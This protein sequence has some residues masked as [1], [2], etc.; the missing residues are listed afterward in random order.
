MYAL[1]TCFFAALFLATGFAKAQSSNRFL[2][3]AVTNH[4]SAFPFTEFGRLFTKEFNPGIEAGVGFY[5]KRGPKHDWFGRLN[6]GYFVHRFVQHALPL[7][8]QLGYRYKLLDRI[9][10]TGAFGVGYL[11]GIPATDVYKLRDGTYE[12]AKV[13]GRA[14]A[15]VSLT[16]GVQY[17]VSKTASKPTSLFLEYGQKLQM[18]FIRSYVPLLPYNNI[19]F[20]IYLGLKTK[21]P[22]P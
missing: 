17:R 20:G 16:A 15:V 2:T 3:L 1:R 8:G 7:Y 11:H 6:A 22:R 18:P 5:W 9:R 12:E 4:H 21:K 14:Q 10:V 19:A 13:L